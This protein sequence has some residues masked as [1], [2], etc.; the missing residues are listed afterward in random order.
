[1]RPANPLAGPRGRRVNRH[2]QPVAAASLFLGVRARIFSCYRLPSQPSM[3]IERLVRPGHHFPAPQQSAG[4][5]PMA[6]SPSVGFSRRAF[7]LF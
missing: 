1:M 3:G 4:P 2:A 6:T 7:A 5:P